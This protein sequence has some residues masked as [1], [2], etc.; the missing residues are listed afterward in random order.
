MSYDFA[1]QTSKPSRPKRKPVN[2]PPR[3]ADATTPT[4]SWVWFVLGVF[5]TLAVQ[6]LV[7]I[8]NT[9]PEINH[10]SKPASVNIS[11]HAATTEVKAGS[12][13]E[14]TTETG[15]LATKKPT[16]NSIPPSSDDSTKVATEPKATINFYDTLPSME[17]PID[18]ATVTKRGLS[19][20]NKVLQTGSFRDKNDAKKQQAFIKKLGLPASIKQ[21]DHQE[22]PWF[23]VIV[24]PFDSRSSLAQARSLLISKNLPSITLNRD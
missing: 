8:I 19:G 7:S 12:S 24:G 21:S 1:K 18:D 10:V 22:K 13:K 3:K 11:P 20:Y 2:Q 23:R 5:T 15:Q 4:K 14:K 9:P 6:A 16:S 17:I